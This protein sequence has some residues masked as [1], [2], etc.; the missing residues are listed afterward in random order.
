[1]TW[2]ESGSTLLL[3]LTVLSGARSGLGETLSCGVTRVSTVADD[4]MS[5]VAASR[6]LRVCEQDVGSE[7]VDIVVRN[8]EH[9]VQRWTDSVSGMLVREFRVLAADLTGDGLDDIAVATRNTVSNGMAI[10]SWTVCAIDGAAVASH[11]DCVS[12]EDFGFMSYFARQPG[13]PGC[14][15]LQTA[16]RWGKEPGR[17]SGLYLVGR[18]L[19]YSRGSFIPVASRPLVA[20]RYLYSFERKRTSHYNSDTPLAWFRDARVRSV[21]CPDPLCE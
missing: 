8:G 15:L 21:T 10:A 9:E 16:W 12:V 7:D 13:S 19:R 4:A 20:R 17:G 1:M 6:G 3:A 14:L 5:C 11:P 2:N 18:W